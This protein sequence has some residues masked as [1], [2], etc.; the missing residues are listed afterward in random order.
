[1]HLDHKK[2]VA[3]TCRRLFSFYL[4]GPV[5]PRPSNGLPFA[6]RAFRRAKRVLSAAGTAE[7]TDLLPLQW[8]ETTALPADR[9]FPPKTVCPQPSVGKALS[10]ETPLWPHSFSALPTTRGVYH[11]PHRQKTPENRP[12]RGGQMSLGKCCRAAGDMAGGPRPTRHPL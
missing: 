6:D 8:A 7:T 2:K 12:G 9:L 4:S 5:K 11:R 10:A 3:D 1:M